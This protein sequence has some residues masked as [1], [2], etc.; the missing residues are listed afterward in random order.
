MVVVV[1]EGCTVVV[2]MGTVVVEGCA[3]VEVGAGSGAACAVGGTVEVGTP[4]AAF[5]VLSP[6][7]AEFEQAMT[8]ATIPSEATIDRR[9]TELSAVAFVNHPPTMRSERAVAQLGSAPAL[10]AGGRRFES[11]QPDPRLGSPVEP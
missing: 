8:R 11:D 7:M 4:A 6:E 10:G 9:V 2:V 3:V 1:L 5:P